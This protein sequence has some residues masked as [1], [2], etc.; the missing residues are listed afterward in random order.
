MRLMIKRNKSLGMLYTLVTQRTKVLS[1][2][3]N[4]E[5]NLRQQNKRH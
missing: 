3:R 1:K 4:I 2:E 5:L